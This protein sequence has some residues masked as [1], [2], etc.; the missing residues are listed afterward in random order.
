MKNQFWAVGWAGLWKTGLGR[1]WATFEGGYFNFLWSKKKFFFFWKHCSVRTEKL[2]R[3]KVKKKFIFWGEEFFF[4]EKPVFF[5]AENKTV[6]RR[7]PNPNVCLLVW[8]TYLMDGRKWNII[9]LK[10]RHACQKVVSINRL[11]RGTTTNALVS[12]I[13]YF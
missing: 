11:L 2:H 4:L 8:A 7:G 12:N 6:I 5:R 1:L 13:K 10:D 9:A 3:K